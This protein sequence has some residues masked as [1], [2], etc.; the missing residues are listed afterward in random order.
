MP[1]SLGLRWTRKATNSTTPHARNSKAA[2]CGTRLPA[3]SCGIKGRPRRRKAETS[4]VSRMKATPA[5]CTAISPPHQANASQST[6]ASSTNRRA[7]TLSGSS[8]ARVLRRAGSCHAQ[9]I[10]HARS[11]TSRRASISIRRGER[12]RQASRTPAAAMASPM[13]LPPGGAK[14]LPASRA[15]EARRRRAAIHWGSPIAAK[16]NGYRISCDRREAGCDST[17]RPRRGQQE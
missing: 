5:A 7:A 8:T 17:I 9:A 14:T 4:S 3:I 1:L 6:N 16:L 13:N 10:I 15:G 2:S 11:L 12:R